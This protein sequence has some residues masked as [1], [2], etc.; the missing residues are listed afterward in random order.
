MQLQLLAI[1]DAE[2]LAYR[3]QSHL[4]RGEQHQA[5]D[6][7]GKALATDPD[8]ALAYGVRALVHRAGQ[9]ST[10]CEADCDS[11]GPPGTRAP[12]GLFRP[13]HGAA[14]QRGHGGGPRPTATPRWH[15]RPGTLE[16]T[17]AAA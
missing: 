16:S 14:C 8:C 12:R 1:K 9:R 7:C 4:I 6:D 17:T 5:L 10:E 13:R 15:W 2:R 11:G 3:A